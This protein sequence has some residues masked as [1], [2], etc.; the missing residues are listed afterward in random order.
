MC[1]YGCFSIQRIEYG[2]DEYQV[3]ASVYQSFYLGRIGSEQRI[4]RNVPVG[5][6]IHVGR[7]GKGAVGRPYGACDETGFLR[8]TVLR[9]YLPR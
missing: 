1:H 6:I 2:F 7:Y 9:R 4:E 3:A 5:R 8:R